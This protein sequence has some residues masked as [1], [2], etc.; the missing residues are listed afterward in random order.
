[1]DGSEQAEKPMRILVVDDHADGA[2]S[3]CMVLTVFGHDVRVAR[4]GPHAFE[5]I[6][7]FEPEVAIVDI[8]LPGMS[9]YEVA[10]KLRTL[11]ATRGATLIALTGYGQDEDRRRALDAGFDHHLTKPVQPLD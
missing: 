8:G 10:R 6:K 4:D 11:P 5:T 7:T 9:G 3:L 2:N 1:T